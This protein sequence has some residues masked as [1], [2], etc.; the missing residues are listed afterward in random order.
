MICAVKPTGII[1][2]YATRAEKQDVSPKT[3]DEDSKDHVRIQY[4]VIIV[5][6]LD[7]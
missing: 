4:D 5:R 3:A 1:Q 2:E 7:M 6:V